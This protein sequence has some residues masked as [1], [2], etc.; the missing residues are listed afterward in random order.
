M[1]ELQAQTTDECLST[2][3]SGK[4]GHAGGHYF[5]DLS[6]GIV[7]DLYFTNEARGWE[8]PISGDKVSAARAGAR[9]DSLAG[10]TDWDSVETEWTTVE[11]SAGQ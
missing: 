3:C 4:A 11:R 8:W 7:A 1:S 10:I 9:S 2:W 6:E 5:K